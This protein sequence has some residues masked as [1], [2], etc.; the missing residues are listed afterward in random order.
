MM[1][2]NEQ[3]YELLN[4]RHACKEFDK[5][6]KITADDLNLILDAGRLAPSSMGIE[7]WKFLVIERP[8]LIDDLIAVSPGGKKQLAT[9]S[10]LVVILSRKAADL[11]HDAAYLDNL[12]VNVKKIPDTTLPMF[13]GMVKNI[14]DVR[15]N[16]STE[17]MQAYSNMQAYLAIQN[18]AMVAAMRGIDTCIIGGF[19]GPAAQD[20][21]LKHQA[22]DPEHFVLNMMLP[23]GYRL[24]D[25]TPKTRQA[26][27]EVVQ[28]IK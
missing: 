3:I 4:F 24:H 20:V 1:M 6:K 25:Q 17:A 26:F 10:R 21:L 22:I 27:D 15:F 16:G 9:C 11:Q 12:L 14:Q 5:S 18:M 7:P 28:W 8:A 23:L 19:D 2:T 13:K